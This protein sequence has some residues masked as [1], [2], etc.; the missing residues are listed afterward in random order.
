MRRRRRRRRKKNGDEEMVHEGSRQR[1]SERPRG[2]EYT[3]KEEEM[4]RR[5][6]ERWEAE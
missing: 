1:K 3:W 6:G 5:R 4:L 2:K